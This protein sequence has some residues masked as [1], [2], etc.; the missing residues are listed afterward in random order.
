MKQGGNPGT[1]TFAEGNFNIS[2]STI[3]AIGFVCYIGSFLL[4]TRLVVLFDL[5]YIYP[6]TA[7]IVQI[8]TLVISYLVFHEKISV[9]GII[10]AI[11]VI[12]GIIVM[13]LK[14]SDTSN[15]VAVKNNVTTNID[16]RI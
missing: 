13:N 2:M 15:S 14:F 8:V 1:I 3:S 16:N 12:V 11:L 10:G 6:L 4:F 5:S 9:N 7:G